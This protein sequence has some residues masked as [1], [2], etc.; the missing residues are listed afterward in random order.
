MT[1]K[2]KILQF[3]E[4]ETEANIKESR[5]DFDSCTAGVISKLLFLD[6][7]NI[8]RILNEL[9]RENILIKISGK[10]IKYI[11]KICSTKL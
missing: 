11:S 5:F 1:N 8:S 7:T 4:S 2:E 6:R 9:Y 3:I 10:P